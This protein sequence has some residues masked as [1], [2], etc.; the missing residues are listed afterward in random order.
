MTI[1]TGI[2]PKCLPVL[3]AESVLLKM[4]VSLELQLS[5]EPQQK[6][7][8]VILVDNGCLPRLYSC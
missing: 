7:I 1:S 4:A 6:M 3:S 2:I 8:L 5:T